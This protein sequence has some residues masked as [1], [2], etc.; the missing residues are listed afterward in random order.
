MKIKCDKCGEDISLLVDKCIE[1]YIPGRIKCP[2][3]GKLQDRYISEA[4][5]MTYFTISCLGYIIAA[6]ILMKTVELIGFKWYMIVI[7]LLAFVGIYFLQKSLSRLVYIKAYG[8]TDYKNS[9]VMEDCKSITKRMRIQYAVFICLIIM[10]GTGT[11]DIWIFIVAGLVFT[12][13]SYI[14][15]K[16]LIKKEKASTVK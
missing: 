2:K 5:L 16:L 12:I 14:K 3:C 1:E 9:T 7:L 4:D 10:L 8:K 11:Y 13:V 15:L 6:Y